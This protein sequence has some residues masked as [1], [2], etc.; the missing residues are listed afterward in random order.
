MSKLDRVV[1]VWQPWSLV[2]WPSYISIKDQVGAALALG[3][4]AIAIKGTNRNVI[5]GAKEKM[6]YPDNQHSNDHLEVEAK[7]RGLEVDLWCYLSLQHPAVEAEAVIEANARWNPWHIFLDVQGH[8][9]PYAQNTGAFLRSLG[10]LYRHDGTPVKVWLQSYR[11]PSAHPEIDWVKWLSYVGQDKLYLLEG[12]APQAYYVG[13]QDSIADYKRM[14][15]DYYKIEDQIKRSLNWFVTLPT[16]REH[17]WQPTPESLEAGISFLRDTLEDRLVGF[18]FFRLGW[19]MNERLTDVWSML[20]AYDW[21]EEEELEP[22]P[23]PF[24]ERPEPER[25]E[26]VGGDLRHRGV[27]NNAS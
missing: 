23:I 9:K 1:S 25:W 5:F 12:I 24:E 7:A 11:R 17:G 19:L 6:I 18:N 4:R 15:Q 3:V 26:I 13:T 14:L 2:R 16:Y 21:G 27:I 10:R 20:L 22:E 8:V